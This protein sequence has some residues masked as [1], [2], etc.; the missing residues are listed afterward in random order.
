M[1]ILTGVLSAGRAMAEARMTDSCVV[2]RKTSGTWDEDAGDYVDADIE[3]YSGV[4]RIAFTAS[5]PANINAGS[6]LQ[7]LGQLE[8]HVPVNA[9]IFAPDDVVTISQSGTRPDQVGRKFFIVAPFDGSQ[10]TA[11]RYKVEASDAR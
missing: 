10:T 9:E 5:T 6:A 11:L 1:T 2:T 7:S 3:I 8:I 4:C